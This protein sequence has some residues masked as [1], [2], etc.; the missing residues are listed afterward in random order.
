[1][2]KSSKSVVGPENPE[3]TSE[4]L[5]RAKRLDELPEGVQ[6]ALKGR[7]PQKAPTKKLVSIR[8]SQDVLAAIRAMGEG[9]QSRIDDALRSQFVKENRSVAKRA[10]RKVA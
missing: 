9:W 8:L 1:M 3:W 4:K 2:R 7:G 6:K 10:R 5:A